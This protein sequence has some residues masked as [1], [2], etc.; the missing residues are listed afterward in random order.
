MLFLKFEV[1]I[2]K[3]SNNTLD[4][5]VVLLMIEFTI[6]VPKVSKVNSVWRC[7]IV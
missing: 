3:K 2:V 5:N 6:R 4:M 1:V 7:V